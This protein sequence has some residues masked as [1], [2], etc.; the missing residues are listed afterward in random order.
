MLKFLNS[1]E[2]M[3][4]RSVGKYATFPKISRAR[5]LPGFEFRVGRDNGI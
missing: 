5:L 1:E 3:I 4:H 2:P